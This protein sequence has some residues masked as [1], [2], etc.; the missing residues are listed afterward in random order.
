MMWYENKQE[1]PDASDYT[2]NYELIAKTLNNPY[3][4]H[5]HTHTHTHTHYT[6]MLF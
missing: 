6:H 4:L 3:T 1:M 2:D 5:T